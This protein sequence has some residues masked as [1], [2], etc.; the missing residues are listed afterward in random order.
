[1]RK[2]LLVGVILLTWVPWYTPAAAAP[3]ATPT[4]EQ[5]NCDLPGIG[6]DIADR[7][8]CGTIRVPRNHARPE[9]GTFGLAVVVVK[10]EMQPSHSDPVVYISGGPG[11]PLTIYAAYQARKPY[12]PSRNLI[13]VDQRGTGR[14]E[15]SLCPDASRSLLDAA[16]PVILQDSLDAQAR[17]HAAYM[18]C[19]D[20]AKARGIDLGDFGTRITAE[21]FD[22]VRRALKVE[23]WNVYGESYGATVAMTLAALHPETVR[24]MVLDSMQPPDPVPR[25]STIVADARNAFFTVCARDPACSA[26][27]PDLAETYR[28]TLL[29][30]DQRPLAVKAPRQL[31]Q[32]GDELRVT[33]PVFEFIV[34]QL[35]YDPTAY[36]TLPRLIR[37]VHDGASDSLVPVLASL[38][39]AAATRNPATHAAVECRDRAHFRNPPAAPGNVSDRLQLN[40]ICGDWSVLG[41]PPLLPRGGRVPTLVLTGQL[42]P[43][44]RPDMARNTAGSNGA[45]HVVEFPGV[46]HNVRHFSTCG[47]RIAAAFIVDPNRAPDTACVD[48]GPSIPFAPPG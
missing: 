5:T 26:A 15:P 22:W 47:E 6:S 10:S 24:S 35:L 18:T 30:L 17:R 19:R 25:S 32:F 13:L 1:M 11:E 48:Q 14:S 3:D 7:L 9:A 12:A 40:G 33:A 39:A 36:P 8:L 34:A 28:Q 38:H 27:Y 37:S 4:F 45:L 31:R 23:R 41:P 43:V 21:D 29:R 44:I 16:L 2:H 20:E 46:G 42:D